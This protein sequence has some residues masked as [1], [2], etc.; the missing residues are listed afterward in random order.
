MDNHHHLILQTP[1]ANLSR[2]MQWFNTSYSAW[3]NARHGRVGS[4]WQGRFRDVLVEDG[5]WAYA[6]STYVHLNPLRIAG[7]GLDKNGRVLEAKGFRKPTPE[8]VTERLKR[9][10]A[11]RWSSYRAYAGYRAPPSWLTVGKLLKRADEDPKRCR[12]AYREELKWQ[13]TNG[14]DASRS[15]GLRDV[16]AIGSTRFAR[17]I[18]A[19]VAGRE[20]GLQAKRALRRRTTPGEV[21]AIVEELR[22]ES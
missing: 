14:V 2:G 3:F 21:R 15:E 6:L 9:L 13:L 22:G 16:I 5:S 7:L 18:R 1:E 11:F 12:A 19:A 17:G 10:R 20:E 4:L 8:Q